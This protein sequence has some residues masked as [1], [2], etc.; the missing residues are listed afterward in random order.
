[1]AN[2]VV[3]TSTYD[4]TVYALRARDGAILWR[5]RMA[6]GVNA[7]PSVAGDVLLVGA[8]VRRS[9]GAPAELVAFDLR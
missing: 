8:G 5:S 7:C 3:F 1:M 9:S 4:G 2:D 6:A